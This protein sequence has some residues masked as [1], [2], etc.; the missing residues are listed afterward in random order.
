LITNE[1]RPQRFEDIAGQKLNN[2]ILKSIVDNPGGAPQSIILQGPFGSGKCVVGDSYIKT[3]SGLRRIRDLFEGRDLV[4]DTFYDVDNL[5]VLNEGREESISQI[6][7]SGEKDTIKLKTELDIDIEGSRKHPVYVWNKEEFKAEWKKL[8]EV[9]VGDVVIMDLSP[10]NIKD[11]ESNKN[12]QDIP[13]FKTLRYKIKELSAVGYERKSVANKL[14]ISESAVGRVLRGDNKKNDF[15]MPSKISNHLAYFLGL[16]AGDGSYKNRISF[17]SADDCLLDWVKDFI[18]NAFNSRVTLIKDKIRDNLYSLSMKENGDLLMKWF[19]ML[20]I[21]GEDSSN[22]SVPKIIRDSSWENQLFFVR[23]LMDTDGSASKE[24]N[25][26]ISLNSEELIDFIRHT[27]LSYG[28]ISTKSKRGKSYRLHYRVNNNLDKLFLMN[29]KKELVGN[30]ENKL[31]SHT[32]RIPG[33]LKKAEE[34]VDYYHFRKTHYNEFSLLENIKYQYNDDLPMASYQSLLDY[35]DRYRLRDLKG[36]EV[37]NNYYFNRVVGIENDRK[38]LFD[39]T[40]PESHRFV[41]NSHIVHNTTSAR[42]VAKALNCEKDG[43]EPCLV[44]NTC[45][46][47][48]Q[49]SPFYEEYDSAVV[50]NVD[51]I[52][53][54]RDTFHLTLSNSWKIVVF[55]EIHLASRQAQSA[56][57]KVIEEAPTKV[58]FLFCTTNVDKII[59]TI[60]S[61]SLELRFKLVSAEDTIEN[62]EKVIQKLEEEVPEDILELIAKRSRG[63][64]RDAHMYL[65]QYLMIGEE[66]FRESAK[67]SEE[68]LLKYFKGLAIGDKEMV[69]KALDELLTFPLADLKIDFQQ[70]IL[71]L[72][73]VLAGSRK[74]SEREKEIVRTLGAKLLKLV[75]QASSEWVLNSFES[76][77]AFQTCLLSLF[78]LINSSKNKS[79]SSKKSRYQRA[80]K[81]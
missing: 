24:G 5:T 18:E 48:I 56:L 4:K 53:E 44:C 72:V 13:V 54:L 79:K 37:N 70:V 22:K 15:H 26:E 6:Y 16:M 62:L 35:L 21:R 58:M 66:D 1:F 47:D 60:R 74:G 71:D 28:M 49:N 51:K 36:L 20:N 42:V 3:G 77:M 9:D 55:D 67:T 14:G 61:R 33:S 64:M 80:K 30:V 46:E 45:Q 40:N 38:E 52:R 39:L 69:F 23:G 81:G 57:L 43:V 34:I 2:R 25:V 63:H 76:D 32:N 8:S 41:A 50:G 68:H 10:V 12:N 17:H 29:R 31:Q 78:Q 73:S 7:Y 75:Q 59:P 27:T 65:D 11:I 19:D